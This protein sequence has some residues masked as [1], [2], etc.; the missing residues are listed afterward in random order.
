M[1]GINVKREPVKGK[2]AKE[3]KERMRRIVSG[4]LSESDREEIR[5]HKEAMKEVIVTWK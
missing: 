4:E 5:K 3:I 1:L 2:F